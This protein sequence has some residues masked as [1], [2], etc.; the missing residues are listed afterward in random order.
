MQQFSVQCSNF[1]K[2]LPRLRTTFFTVERGLSLEAERT[3]SMRITFALGLAAAIALI[4]SVAA[5]A[6]AHS[7]GYGPYGYGG[8]YGAYRGGAYDAYRGRAYDAY[9]G[10]AENFSGTSVPYD[11]SGPG[12]NDFQLQGR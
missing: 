12:W 2:A 1:S 10:S 11:A 6:Q 9:R 4:A 8:P 3:R 5:D 7:P